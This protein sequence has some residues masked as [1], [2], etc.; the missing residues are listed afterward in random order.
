MF[1]SNGQL[2]I[3]QH[4]SSD[5]QS[6]F[7]LAV[8]PAHCVN[9]LDHDDYILTVCDYIGMTILSCTAL[10]S[11][12]RIIITVLYLSICSATTYF[13]TLFTYN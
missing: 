2:T 10:L 3:Y 11:G 8:S 9:F 1:M 5:Q 4:L 6:T 7:R 13:I 12:V